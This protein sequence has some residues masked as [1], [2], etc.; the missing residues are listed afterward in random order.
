MWRAKRRNEAFPTGIRKCG[1]DGQ[2]ISA[3]LPDAPPMYGGHAHRAPT[4]GTGAVETQLRA[5]E[6]EGN[7]SF[8]LLHQ[9]SSHVDHGDASVGEEA[10]GSAFLLTH[11]GDGTEAT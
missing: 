10:Q 11:P 3:G 6:K 2:S 4:Q 5:P 8:P 9:R 7:H 1:K